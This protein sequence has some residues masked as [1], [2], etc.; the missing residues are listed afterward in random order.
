[1]RTITLL[2]LST[3]ILTAEP[4]PVDLP[5][6]VSVE[7]AVTVLQPIEVSKVEI[8]RIVIDTTAQEIS[9]QTTAGNQTITL[10][11]RAYEAIAESFR[12]QFAQSIAP[13]IESRLRSEASSR[14]E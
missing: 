9:F 10:S 1:M 7:R 8:S 12:E 13:L 14:G 2:L 11:G 6:P 5:N 3:A 4:I